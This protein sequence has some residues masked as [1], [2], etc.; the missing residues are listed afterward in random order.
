[1]VFHCTI[2]LLACAVEVFCGV[3]YGPAFVEEDFEAVFVGE[4]VALCPAP[5]FLRVAGGFFQH[6]FFASA[7]DGDE[8]DGDISRRDFDGVG[9]F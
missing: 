4:F 3:G 7:A 5:A 9:G 6:D 2:Y 8:G 1:M